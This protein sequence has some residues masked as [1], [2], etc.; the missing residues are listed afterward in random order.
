MIK[1]FFLKINKKQI[2]II[3]QNEKIKKNINKIKKEAFFLF[4]KHSIKLKCLL[5]C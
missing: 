4:L 1:F 3:N 5:I 2:K